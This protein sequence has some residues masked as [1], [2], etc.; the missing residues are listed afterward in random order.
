MPRN[1]G[2]MIVASAVEELQESLDDA[3]I[4]FREVYNAS[5]CLLTK[6][7]AV[8]SVKGIR[9]HLAQRSMWYVEVVIDS[10]VK[11]SRLTAHYRLMDGELLDPAF[12]CEVGELASL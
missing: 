3:R 12:D 2:R 1:T 7:L 6:D 11:Y 8:N 4:V 9:A 5:M 10:S